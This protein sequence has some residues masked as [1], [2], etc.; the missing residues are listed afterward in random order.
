MSARLRLTLTYTAVFAVAGAALMIVSYALVDASLKGLPVNPAQYMGVRGLPWFGGG[1]VPQMPFESLLESVRGALATHSLH[2]LELQYALVFGA[3]LLLSAG[4]GWWTAGR[5]L[6]PLRTITNTA[7]RVSRDR[8]QERI[9]LDGPADELRELADTFDGML[10]RLQAAFDSQQRF[11]ANAS[12]EL[13]TPLSVIRTEVDV[14]LADDAGV[15]AELLHTREVVREAVDRSER[16]IDSLLTLARSD[17]GAP[18]SDPVALDA[19]A[20]RCLGELDAE[21][22]AAGLSVDTVALRPALACGEPDLLERVVDNLIEN[23]LRHNAA[24]GWMRIESGTRGRTAWFRVANGGAVIERGDLQQLVEPFRR[25]GAARTGRGVGLG[26]SI[27]S[28]VVRLH[29]GRLAL[30]ALPAGGLLAEVELPG[31]ARVPFVAEARGRPAA[32][33]RPVG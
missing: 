11:V 26:L 14:A 18:G 17:G 31:A 1:P 8:L 7:R 29:G 33:A 3:M 16:L 9:A 12:H 32:L 23:A 27:V 5:V 13:R 10:D 28:S 21:I 25:L 4:L 6:R 30:S 15:P 24:G 22:A 19:R 2:R 20:R